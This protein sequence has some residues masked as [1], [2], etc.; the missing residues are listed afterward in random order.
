MGSNPGTFPCTEIIIYIR[1]LLAIR[2]ALPSYPLKQEAEGSGRSRERQH[3]GQALRCHRL[4][5]TSGARRPGPL[6]RCHLAGGHRAPERASAGRLRI[7]R[8]PRGPGLSMSSDRGRRKS[9]NGQPLRDWAGLHELISVAV[10]ETCAQ[11]NARGMRPPVLS[12]QGPAV[13]PF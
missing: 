9:W 3:L 13:T 1:K 10:R 5:I 11:T 4:V 7:S 2:D 6:L 8:A 12:I